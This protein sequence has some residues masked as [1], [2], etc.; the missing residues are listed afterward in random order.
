MSRRRVPLLGR[1][2]RWGSASHV[3]SCTHF[4]QALTLLGLRQETGHGS[5]G[6]GGKVPAALMDVHS[7]KVTHEV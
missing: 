6:G 3:R 5:A 2:G 7:I 1:R 4:S